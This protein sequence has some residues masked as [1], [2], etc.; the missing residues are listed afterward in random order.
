[1]SC[2]PPWVCA[3][4]PS[5][6]STHPNK[7]LRTHIKLP[8]AYQSAHPPP[9]RPPQVHESF[10][11]ERTSFFHPSAHKTMLAPPLSPPQNGAKRQHSC[12]SFPRCTSRSFWS[13][14]H[15]LTH[16]PTEQC[17]APLFSPS[18]RSKAAT[19]LTFLPPF[20]SQVHESFSLERAYILFST[21][22]L[23]HLVITDDHNRVKGIVTRK[24]LVGGVF[25]FSLFSFSRI[26]GERFFM[27]PRRQRPGQGHRHAQGPGGCWAVQRRRAEE[28]LFCIGCDG[29]VKGIAT[30]QDLVGGLGAG[31]GVE[32]GLGVAPLRWSI[33]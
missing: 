1:M 29:R 27:H 15:P 11:L 30:C 3:T 19:F 33:P 9:Q 25:G 10:S 32:A 24:D 14:P 28:C 22:G 16:P 20:L 17:S 8:H 6:P 5:P 31:T 21:M 26:L 2:S 7:Q 4:A 23:R 12:I 18:E 13:A